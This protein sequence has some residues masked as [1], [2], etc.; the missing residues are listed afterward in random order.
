MSTVRLYGR[1][2]QLQV[3]VRLL[4]AW[5]AVMQFHN[6]ILKPWCNVSADCSASSWRLRTVRASLTN[7]STPPH[8]TDFT[9]VV[10]AAGQDAGLS[11]EV[12]TVTGLPALEISVPADSA[13]YWTAPGLLAGQSSLYVRVEMR[14]KLVI[15]ACCQ[16]IVVN[17]C[18][19][20]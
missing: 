13:I 4:S 6:S 17:W 11:V 5:A 16:L 10:S 9:V 19:F 8:S 14:D 1:D 3:R 7:S 20:P 18:L 2:T 12:V 15:E